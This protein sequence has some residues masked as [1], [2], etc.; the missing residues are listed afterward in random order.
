VTARLAGISDLWSIDLGS[1]A[2]WLFYLTVIGLVFVESGLVIG[3]LL[4]GDSLLFAA[5]LVV[6]EPGSGLSL[7]LLA[8]GVFLAAVVGTG[9]GYWTGLRLGR[10]WLEGRSARTTA[11]LRRAEVFYQRYGW[12]ALVAARFI[13]WFRT[14]TPVL[15]GIARMPLPRLLSAN[16]VGAAVWGPGLVIAGYVGHA[17]PAVRTIA[18]AVAGTAIAASVLVPVVG[19]IR[20]RLTR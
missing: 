2:A 14:F 16:L 1:M 17:Q 11:H 4:P 5:G 19:L 12:W 13:P 3:F 7:P 15:A 9:T 10:P 20:R 18:Y 6:A 8:I